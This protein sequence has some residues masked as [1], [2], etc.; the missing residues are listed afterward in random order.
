MRSKAG[1]LEEEGMKNDPKAAMR[2]RVTPYPTSRAPGRRL[3][4]ITAT[5]EEGS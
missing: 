3:W 2:E 4:E 5:T 1:T